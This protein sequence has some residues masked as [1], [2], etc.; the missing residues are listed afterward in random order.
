MLYLRPCGNRFDA[1]SMV[2]RM[3]WAVASAFDPGVWNIA[4]ATAQPAERL[5]RNLKRAGLV[6]RRLVEDAGGDLDVLGLQ[7]LRDVVRG[8]AERLQAVGIE[9]DPH[10]VIAAAEHDDGAHALNA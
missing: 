9:P 10:G 6:D 8:H 3:S 2:L 4:I 1:V 7:R 5:H